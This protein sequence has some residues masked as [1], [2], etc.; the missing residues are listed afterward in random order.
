MQDK[1]LDQT[2]ACVTIGHAQSSSVPMT[3]TSSDMVLAC[4]TLSC[5]DDQ[6]CHTIFEYHYVGPS[7]GSDTSKVHNSQ[8]PKFTCRVWS[9]PSG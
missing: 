8:R 3:L 2:Q 9:L 4:D 7:Y 6:L 5:H 1:V